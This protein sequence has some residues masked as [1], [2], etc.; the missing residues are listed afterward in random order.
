[1]SIA[2]TYSD[3][4]YPARGGVVADERRTHL[5]NRVS[6]GAILAGVVAA[7]VMQI[8]LN[9]LGLGIG[10]AS[11]DAANTADNPSASGI[12]MT[13]G[14]WWIASAIIAAFVGGIVS[15]RLCGAGSANT[16]RW[17]GF[18]T[19]AT[20][21]LVVFVLLT[22][23][24]GNI[25]GGTFSALGS[26][27]GGAGRAAASAVGGAAQ[28]ADGD[29][30]Q[31]QVRRLIKPDD[32]QSVQDDVVSYVKTALNGDQNAANAARDRAVAS[33][34][35]AANVSPDEARGRL[36]QLETQYKQT[37][38]QAKQQAQQAAETARKGIAAAG[39]FGALVLVLGALAGWLGGGI[40]APRRETTLIDVA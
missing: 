19:W 27:I 5:L 16:A 35:K 22:S 28:A 38:D 11:L 9:I 10:A 29:A 18:V 20:A 8:L 3:T 24:V 31:A 40:G 36:T 34:A 4:A 14:I 26:T 7:L 32:A 23:A 1:M 12:S 21:T 37:V 33:L 39:L 17:H 25:V 15:G 13:A 2:P 30:L 6:W